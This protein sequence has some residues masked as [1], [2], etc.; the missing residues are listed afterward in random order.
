VLDGPARKKAKD[1]FSLNC[2]G[3]SPR[4]GR[5]SEG[6]AAAPTVRDRGTLANREKAFRAGLRQRLDSSGWRSRAAFE[7][8]LEERSIGGAV[9]GRPV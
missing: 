9:K 7:S 5:R 4:F 3:P 6:S 2:P 1:I 8:S